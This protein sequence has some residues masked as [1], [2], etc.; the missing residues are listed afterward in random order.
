MD[1]RKFSKNYEQ[2]LFFDEYNFGVSGEAN[3][4]FGTNSYIPRSFSF[5]GTVNLFGGSMNPFE[6]NVRMQGLEKYIESIFG[7]DA[8]L[9]FDKL[10]HNFKFLYEK[11][12]SFFDFDEDIIGAILRSKRSTDNKLEGFAYKPNYD[13]N[14]PTGYFEHKIFGNDINFYDFEGLD[15]L[16]SLIKKLIPVERIKNIFSKNQEVFIDSG[17]F[18][19]LAYSVPS[20]TGF[21]LVLN[22][23]GAY[24]LDISYFASINN[25]KVWET[26]SLDFTGKLR[27]SLSVE[28][29]ANMQ[30][31]LF[32]GST[33]VKFKSNVYSNYALEANLNVK[34]YTHASLKVKVPQDRNDIFSIRTELISKIEGRD[35][36]LNGINKRFLNTSCTWPTIDQ[37]LGLKVCIDY[38]LPDVSDQSKIYPSLILSGPITFDIHLDKADLSA[39]IFTFDY[40]WKFERD[41]SEASVIFETPNS[42]IPRKLSAILLINPTDYNFTMKLLNGKSTQTFLGLIK[43]SPALKSLE[44]SISENDQKQMQLEMSL[45]RFVESKTRRK[46]IPQFLLTI[47]GQKMAGIK[48]IIEVLDKSDV[49]QYEF[50]LNCETKKLQSGAGGTLTLTDVSA[51]LNSQLMYKVS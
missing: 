14:K 35:S 34:D 9:N 18:V 49:R 4:I 11:I 10:V 31:D 36:F 28:L 20:S 48:G 42:K 50:E 25:D 47:Q 46:L 33:E 44:F 5:N 17:T 12:K 15:E 24:S 30:M 43:N 19:D 37:T 16:S 29:N 6:F 41:H 39:K 40:N 32:Y 7:I 13:F 38:S 45:E 27:P 2:S 26:K 23:F 51:R 8:P 22:G 1:F 3:V 21:P